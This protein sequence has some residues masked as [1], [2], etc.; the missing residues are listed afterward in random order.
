MNGGVP[1]IAESIRR[2]AT[3]S[4]GKRW[5]EL[6]TPD[7]FTAVS[8][9]VRDLLVERALATD[10][11]EQAARAF[12]D[13]SRWARMAIRNVARVG[14]FSSDRAVRE[15]ARDVWNARPTS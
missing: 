8:L 10:A 14:Y 3:Y 9:S 13:R 12:R 5:Q 15:Y 1:A 11:E 7:L 2:H 6:S 4:L